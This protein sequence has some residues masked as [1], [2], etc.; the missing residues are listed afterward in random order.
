MAKTFNAE[1]YIEDATG[2]LIPRAKVHEIDLR[3]DRLVRELVENARAHSGILAE[4]KKDSMDALD[5]FRA[6]SA[7][8]LK[9]KTKTFNT[10]NYQMDSFDGKYR[11]KITT[12][13][14]F[15]FDERLSIAKELIDKAVKAE[16]KGASLN[17]VAIVNKA[18]AIDKEGSVSAAKVL[19]LKQLNIDNPDWK[20]AMEAI[21]QGCKLTRTK[22]YITFYERDEDGK[23]NRIS[24]DIA[25]D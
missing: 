17:L 7:K 20:K 2:A 3:R 16:S 10:P 4:F 15:T 25:D 21:S 22:R 24:L 5:D 19:N 6:E 11:V 13:E 8:E 23:Y 12:A 14:F 18:L 1:D 9:H